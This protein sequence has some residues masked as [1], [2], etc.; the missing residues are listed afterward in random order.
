MVKLKYKYNQIY[1]MT[2]GILIYFWSS[3]GERKEK[4]VEVKY[5]FN[6]SFE[7][8]IIKR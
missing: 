8:H 4:K 2:T 1:T 3:I 7:I 6:Q 5:N